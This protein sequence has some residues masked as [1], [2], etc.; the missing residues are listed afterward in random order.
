[1]GPTRAAPLVLAALLAAAVAWLLVTTSY[2]AI[3]PL[4]WSPTAV[5]S[6]LGV[7]EGY[8]ALNTRARIE[9]RP[10]REPV[11][12]IAV[13]RFAVLAKASSLVGSI[14]GGFFAGLV[15]WLVFQ[16][17]DAAHRDLGP[18]IGGLVGAIILVIAALLLERACRVPKRDDEDENRDAH[19]TRP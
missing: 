13:A 16:S 15:S 11:D 8:M 18:A 19:S 9:R 12:P 1:M 17:T 14:F 6:G 2:N 5:L 3:P 7:L 4:P 10:G